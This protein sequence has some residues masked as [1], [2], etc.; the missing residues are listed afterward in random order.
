MGRSEVYV[1]GA[2]VSFFG[3]LAILLLRCSPLAMVASLED[4]SR[5]EN[6]PMLKHKAADS[7]GFVRVRKADSAVAYLAVRLTSL[8]SG[9]A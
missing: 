9:T 1:F 5:I 4:S 3:F 6:A 2:E 8:R 7:C